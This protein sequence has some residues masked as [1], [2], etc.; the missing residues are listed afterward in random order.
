MG[1]GRGAYSYWSGGSRWWPPWRAVED[2]AGGH[3]DKKNLGNKRGKKEHEDDMRE[4]MAGAVQSIQKYGMLKIG[5]KA[6]DA[7]IM[8][9]IKPKQNYDGT[10]LISAFVV[11]FFETGKF[12][13]A[14]SN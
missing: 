11:V 10:S 14:R 5:Q 1:R 4:I 13:I 7:Y 3:G 6:S 8:A 9:W 12:V 2:L